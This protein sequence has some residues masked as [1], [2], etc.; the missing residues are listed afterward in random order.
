[1]I[2]PISA[3]TLLPHALDALQQVAAA[4]GIGQAD[5]AHADFDFHRI[6]GQIVFDA[7]FARFLGFGRRPVRAAAPSASR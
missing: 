6:D 1:M 5:Q 2:R 4:L 7:L 3:A